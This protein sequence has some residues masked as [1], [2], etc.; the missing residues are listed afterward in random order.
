MRVISRGHADVCLSGGAECKLNPMGI[1]RQQFAGRLAKLEPTDDPALLVRPF[2]EDARGSVLGEGGG[3]LILEAL[4]SA[5]ERGARPVAE[6]AG[7]SASQASCSDTVG[8]VYDEDDTS[9]E[10][11]INNALKSADCSPDDIDAV[12]PLGS[13][14]PHMDAVDARAIHAVFG[15]RAGSVPIITFVPNVG[16][17]GAGTGAIATSL[18][19]K[20]SRR[21]D[22]PGPDRDR[23]CR[24]L[25]ARRRSDRGTPRQ[26]RCDPGLHD[27]HGRTEHRPGAPALRRWGRILVTDVPRVVLTGAG[28]VTPLGCD[29]DTV[30]KR[31]INAESGMAPITRFDARTF[32]TKFAAEVKDY[33][34][35]DFIRDPSLHEHAGLNSQFAL[36]AATQAWNR[37]G[38]SGCS[39]LDRSRIGLYLGAGEGVLDTDN[40]MRTNLRGWEPRD[41]QDRW[42]ALG[43][44]SPRAH[45]GPP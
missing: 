13:G 36:G 20:W 25:G 37:S 3:I 17:C 30:W 6:I 10:S 5:R 41:P 26:A 21:T 45:E 29:L 1:L 7:F 15:E 40:Y 43:Q 18:A 11:A 16:L 32:P 24:D 4:E 39:N 42:C 38:L 34:V 33:D 35:N 27:E 22:A 31:L 9:V 44:G 12:L 8:L 2:S 28:W 14:I 19:A 23:G